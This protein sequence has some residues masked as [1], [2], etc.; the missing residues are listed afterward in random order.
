MYNISLVLV[1]YSGAKVGSGSGQVLDQFFG[2]VPLRFSGF[3][4][5]LRLNLGTAD[6]GVGSGSAFRGWVG[7]GDKNF[8]GPETPSGFGVSG[9]QLHH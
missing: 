7:F 8:W 9:P 5:F 3:R 2:D 1:M 6:V 4:G